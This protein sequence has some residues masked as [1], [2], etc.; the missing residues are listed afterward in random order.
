MLFV[1]KTL[2]RT[3]LDTITM[4]SMAIRKIG[5]KPR[6][7]CGGVSVADLKQ[8]KQQQSIFAGYRL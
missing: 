7:L 2:K 8:P 3:K 6:G 5:V 1:K 4:N